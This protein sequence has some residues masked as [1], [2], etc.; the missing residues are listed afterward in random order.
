[1]SSTASVQ[2]LADEVYRAIAASE[3]EPTRRARIEE[4]VA[5]LGLDTEGSRMPEVSHRIELPGG[6]EI[7]LRHVDG[8]GW[9]A[10]VAGFG[11]DDPL[12]RAR[13]ALERMQ[14]LLGPRALERG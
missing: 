8:D 9:Q 10:T 3:P 5:V 2:A 11:D 7:E 4:L 6:R 1:V 14:E 13:A 12:V